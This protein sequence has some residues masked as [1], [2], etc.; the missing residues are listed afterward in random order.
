MVNRVFLVGNGESRIGYDLEK[1]RPHG[2]IYACNAIYREFLPDVLI[3]V[4]N[5]IMHEIYHA[6]IATKIPCYFRGWTRVPANMYDSIVYAGISK[7]EQEILK[8]HADK[9]IKQNERNNATEFV[10]HGS[11]LSG[12]AR[13]MRKD[14]TTYLKEVNKL[15][16]YISWIQ[17]G[18]KSTNLDDVST[19]VDPGWAAGPTSGNIACLREKPDEVYLIGHDI[20]SDNNKVNNIYKGTN[21]YVSVDNGPTPHFNW[22]RQWRTLFNRNPNVKFIKVN[23]KNDLKAITDQ[24]IPEWYNIKSKNISYISQME[25]DKSLGL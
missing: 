3:S 16:S 24:I 23:K 11:A 20:R 18:D 12:L 17:D 1:L 7:A 2:K 25:L 8:E 15:I 4:D 22:I 14:K 13:I 21:N 6:G 5:G 9:V 10:M 19:E